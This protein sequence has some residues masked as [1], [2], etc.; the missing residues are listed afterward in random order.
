MREFSVYTTGI[1]SLVEDYRRAVAINA[2]RPITMTVSKGPGQSENVTVPAHLPYVRVPINHLDDTTLSQFTISHDWDVSVA[3]GVFPNQDIANPNSLIRPT[4]VKFLHF[5]EVVLPPSDTPPSVDDTPLNNTG[6]PSDK[7]RT[8]I[9]WLAS[10]KSLGTPATT[11]D[12]R[13]VVKD[14]VDVA[15]YL[16][17]PQGRIS[18]AFATNFKCVSVSALDGKLVGTLHQAVAQLIVCKLNVPDE[19][20]TVL[21]RDYGSGDAGDFEIT[22]KA[23]VPDPWM[24]FACTSLDD[25]FQLPSVEEKFGTDM[26]FRLVYGLAAGA[27]PDDYIALPKSINP[28]PNGGGPRPLGSGHCIPPGWSGGSTGGQ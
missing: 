16:R 12:P 13:H 19:E 4:V 14:P 25:A 20:F 3:P 6:I 17:F 26:H 15:A 21:C 1:T 28:A 24:V 5:H 22:F 7:D 27:V 18:T 23:G 2:P 10:M 11:I 9:H 8:S